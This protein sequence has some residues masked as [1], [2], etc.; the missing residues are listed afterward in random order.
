MK[1]QYNGLIGNVFHNLG[2]LY[3]HL[4]EFKKSYECFKKSLIFYKSRFNKSDDTKSIEKVQ[5]YMN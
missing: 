5:K 1:H 2:Y 4:D 3:S